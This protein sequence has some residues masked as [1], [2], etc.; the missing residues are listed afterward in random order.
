[1]TDAVLLVNGKAYA[2]WQ[3]IRVTR[4]I[5]S[6]CGSFDLSIADR[7]DGDSEPWAITEGDECQIK[8]GDTVVLT[9]YV[10]KRSLSLGSEERSLTVSGRDKVGDM[11]DSSAKL[12]QWEFQNIN[13]LKFAQKIAEPFGVPVTLQ[14]GVVGVNVHSKLT[15]DPGEGAWDTIEKVCRLAG[16]LPVSNGQGGIVLTRSASTRCVQDLVQ[17]GNIK[18]GSADY[19]VSQRFHTYK[20]LGQ[21]A[22]PNDEFFGVQASHVK[23]TVID[24]TVTRTT[25]TLIVRPEGNVTTTQAKTRGLWESNVR[26]A[27]G[28]NL[29]VTVFGWTQFD[30]SLWPVNALVNVRAPALGANGDMLVTEV[31]YSLDGSTG[32][33]TKLELKGPEAFNPEPVTKEGFVWKEIASGVKVPP[34]TVSVVKGPIK[35]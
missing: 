11:V 35:P 12:S 24:E 30:G 6:A 22:A 1:M 17:G 29:S 7:W 9:G 15:I 34:K 5:E 3:S 8:L 14:S 23:A 4:S 26:A 25:R 33:T 32:T 31:T 21:H 18:E 28:N 13:A 16:L 19:D 20:V 10:D 27:R 2:G